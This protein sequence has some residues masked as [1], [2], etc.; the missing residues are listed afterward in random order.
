MRKGPEKNGLVERILKEIGKHPDG[1]WV[2]KLS[3]ILKEPVMTIHKYVTRED[4]AGRHIK[5]E[6]RSQEL[7]GHVI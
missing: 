3:R 4:Y 1:I 5:M 7:G 2:R 6:K